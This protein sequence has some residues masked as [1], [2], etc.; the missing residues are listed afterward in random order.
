MRAMMKRFQCRMLQACSATVYNLQGAGLVRI[1]LLPDRSHLDMWPT[2]IMVMSRPACQ[3]RPVVITIMWPSLSPTPPCHS[4]HS[5]AAT[6]TDWNLSILRV[7]LDILLRSI[8]WT[9][10]RSNQQLHW[11]QALTLSIR[12]GASSDAVNV[13]PSLLQLTLSTT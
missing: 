7:T 8:C 4:P 3:L 9:E 10:L 5:P 13:L 2:I 1:S 6:I 12:G 11:L